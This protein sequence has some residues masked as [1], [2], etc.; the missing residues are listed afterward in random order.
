MFDTIIHRWL[1]VPYTL[2]VGVLRNVKKPRAT[3]LFIHGI[4][5]SSA[6]WDET[7]EKLPDDIAIL[8]IDLL[9][10]GESP[11][12]YW[13]LYDA[14]TQAKSVI[15]TLLK[16]RLR[17]RLVVVGHSLGALV[18]IE[19]A[20]R[21]P[22]LVKSL[23]LCAPPLYR[24]S[25]K[26]LLPNGD[27]VLKYIYSRL[28]KHP[29]ELVALSRLAV[30]YK[31]AAK[32]INLTTDNIGSYLATLKASIVNQTS[33]DDLKELQKPVT[34][35]YGAFDAVIIEKNYKRIARDNSSVKLVK[36]L[37][38]HEVTGRFIKP[39]VR[40]IDFHARKKSPKG[41]NEG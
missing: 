39:L 28:D 25:T 22:L 40:E 13:A 34:I 1:K 35:C 10:F 12:P 9:G 6:E 26:R 4:G 32:T 5:T 23:V 33:F 20:K 11:A 18:A 16:L 7:I 27:D 21:Y 41:N 37:A 29:A 24:S 3:L 8:T 17:R 38:G 31:L 14:Q 30:K 2:N 19:V 15:T 36:I